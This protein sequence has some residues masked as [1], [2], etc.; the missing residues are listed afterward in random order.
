M[1][2][3]S[4]NNSIIFLTTLSV[5]LGLVLVGATPQILAQQ[6]E[7]ISRQTNIVEARLEKVNCSE[8]EFAEILELLSKYDVG[9]APLKFS[10]QTD[11]LENQPAKSQ[12][13]LAEGKKS[14]V[15]SLRQSVNCDLRRQ[16]SSEN[17]KAQNQSSPEEKAIGEAIE[18]AFSDA[19]Q[20]TRSFCNLKADK[21]EIVFDIAYTF[22]NANGAKNFAGLFNALSENARKIETPELIAENRLASAIFNNTTVRYANNE[23]FIITRLPR[24]SLDELLKQSVKAEDQ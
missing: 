1:S 21:Q 11:F 9:F 16:K 18:K 10:Y 5:C 13:I 8:L 22:S 6:S 23:V 24:G 12:I 7:I 15:D 4:K 20:I 17:I 2:Q 14:L 3:H 19:F